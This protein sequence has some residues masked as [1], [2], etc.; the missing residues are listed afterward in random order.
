[1]RHPGILSSISV[2]PPPASNLQIRDLDTLAGEVC[3]GAR[4]HAR[5]EEAGVG[6]VLGPAGGGR[7]LAGGPHTPG[8]GVG[9]GAGGAGHLAG[10]S[11]EGSRRFHNHGEGPF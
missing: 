5:P 10:A 4:A 3:R 8:Q 6:A 7:A 2:S 1:M 9:G 11:N